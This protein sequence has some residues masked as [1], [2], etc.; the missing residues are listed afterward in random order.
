M[1]APSLRL[2]SEHSAT[3]F[4]NMSA[5]E[6]PPCHP[7]GPLRARG[8]AAAHVHPASRSAGPPISKGSPSLVPGHRPNPGIVETVF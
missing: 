2:L 7:P 3:L 1:C 6:P 4:A 5:G 8:F